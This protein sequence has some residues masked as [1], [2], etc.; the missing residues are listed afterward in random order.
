MKK[1]FVFIIFIAFLG[2]LGWKVYQKVSASTEVSRRPGSAPVAV[3]TGPIRKTTIRDFSFFTGTLHPRSQFI[4][5]PKIGGRL[6]RLYVNIGDMVKRGQL[7]ALIENDEYLEQVDQA[8][9]EL[10]VAIAKIEESRSTL[11][12]ARLEL[13]RVKALREKN[14]S[15]QSALDA[16]EAKF[17]AQNALHKVDQAQIAQKRAALKAAQIRLAYTSIYASWKD[18]YENRVVGERFVDEGAMLVPNSSIVSILENSVLTAVIYVIE[19]DY[20]KVKIGQE[21]F[22]T[23]DAFPDQRFSGKIV[24]VAPLLKE[25]SRQARVEIEVPNQ[26]DVLKPGMFVRIQIEFDRHDDAT[27]VP[28]TALVKRGGQQGVFI[29]DPQEKKTSFVPLTLGIVNNDLAEVVKPPIS[30]MVVTLGQYLL[31][32]GSA[33]VLPGTSPGHSPKAGGRAMPP[34]KGGQPRPGGRP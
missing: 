14:I 12:I 31:E 2:L 1:L 32:D 7:I 4:V 3:K 10:E 21:A 25:T 24:R 15:S 11:E 27:V 6:E 8:K 29:A 13:E 28:V 33:I 16:A 5:A 23:T 30:G 26:K 19:R 22:A 34:G 17:N 18:G 20:S 9:A